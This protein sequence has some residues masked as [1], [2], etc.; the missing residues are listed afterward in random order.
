VGVIKHKKVDVTSR[1]DRAAQSQDQKP[2]GGTSKDVGKTKAVEQSKSK[3]SE[4]AKEKKKAADLSYH[5]TMRP[6]A[7]SAYK[8]TVKKGG[9]SKS[10]TPG[11]APERSRTSDGGYKGTAAAGRGKEKGNTSGYGSYSDE[12][13]DDYESD[14]SSDMEAA[15]FEV[16]EEDMFSLRLAKK[17]DAEAQKEE[18]ELKQKKEL[19]R[20]M[21]AKMAA[22]NAK[23]RRF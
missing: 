2:K 11:S 1:K 6:A 18:D 12:E 19:R 14:V 17:E 7:E 15:A 5:G 22:D 20:K 23:K 21:L 8:G 13:E 4:P 3:A 9:P 10:R 16:E